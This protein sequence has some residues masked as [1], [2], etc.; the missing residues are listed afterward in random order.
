MIYADHAATTFVSEEARAAALPFFGT[1][2]GNASSVYAF[3]RRARRQVEEAR[4]ST[5]GCVGASA[6][7]IVF[8]GGGSLI[9][10]LDQLCQEKTGITTM[11]AEAPLTAVAIGTGKFIEF[12]NG[13]SAD[14]KKEY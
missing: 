13:D 10:G 4:V 6:E 7:E 3:G 5:A 1:D 2:Y 11:I 14:A 12:Q 8:T 9:Y